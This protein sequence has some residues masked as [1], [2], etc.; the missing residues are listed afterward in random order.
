MRVTILFV[1]LF[2]FSSGLWATKVDP[3]TTSFSHHE[4]KRY[5]VDTFDFSGEYP[6]LENIDIDARRKKRVE[7]N[8][9][10]EYPLLEKINY[11]GSFGSLAGRLTGKFSSLSSVTISCSSAAMQLDFSGKW[12]K[13]CEITIRGSTGD[14]LL[15]LPKD[16]GV[17]VKTKTSPT[18]K[19][20]NLSLS[21]KGWGWMN[22]TFVNEHYAVSPIL[23]TINIEATKANVIIK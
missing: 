15:V 19:V 8:L 2:L 12:E 17:L 7:L 4:E 22:K 21:K 20:Q 1:V 3:E 16:I 18:G 10:G 9:T 5:R 6:Q 13:N 14:I 23:L 11:E